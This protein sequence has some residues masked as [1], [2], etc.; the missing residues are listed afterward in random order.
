M[1]PLNCGKVFASER[2]SDLTSTQP[3]REFVEWMRVYGSL[4][5]DRL[6]QKIRERLGDSR[7]V[8]KI[9]DPGDEQIFNLMVIRMAVFDAALMGDSRRTDLC[10]LARQIQQHFPSFWVNLGRELSWNGAGKL[11]AEARRI[12]KDDIY[13][14]QPDGVIDTFRS[15]LVGVVSYD[16]FLA[17]TSS[18]PLSEGQEA[19]GPALYR[20][21]L[22]TSSHALMV[23]ASLKASLAPLVEERIVNKNSTS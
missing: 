9:E 16:S 14:R 19:V 21:T 3:W 17:T 23:A 8:S 1:K 6:E 7:G 11:V 18:K 10:A 12:C 15:T 13:R 5:P 4:D 2:L 22:R 20:S